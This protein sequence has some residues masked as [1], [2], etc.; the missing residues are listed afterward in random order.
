MSNLPKSGLPFRQIAALI[1]AIAVFLPAYSYAQVVAL[2]KSES[3]D[4]KRTGWLPY[5][6]S[7]DSLDTAIGAGAFTAGGMEIAAYFRQLKP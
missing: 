4:D 5:F 6:F 3:I 7:T 2:D 1:V